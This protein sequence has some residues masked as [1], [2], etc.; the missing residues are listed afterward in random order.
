MI[1]ALGV[2]MARSNWLIMLLVC[3]L[4]ARTRVRPG[5]RATSLGASLSQALHR[6]GQHCVPSTPSFIGYIWKFALP[7]LIPV[8]ALLSILFFSGLMQSSIH[9]WR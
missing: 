6:V 1:W 2:V 8:F 9:S 5:N 4:V 7:I 3:S